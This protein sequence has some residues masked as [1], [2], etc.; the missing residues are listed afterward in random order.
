MWSFP[1]ISGSILR[2]ARRTKSQRQNNARAPLGLMRGLG[3]TE[4]AVVGEVRDPL[5]DQIGGFDL[6]ELV[7]ISRAPTAEGLAVAHELHAAERGVDALAVGVVL[8]PD[9]D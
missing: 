5:S 2:R 8:R 4:T 7:G 6:V 3:A 9:L 1:R